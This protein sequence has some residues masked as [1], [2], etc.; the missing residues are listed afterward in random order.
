MK[1]FDSV[2]EKELYFLNQ[3][4]DNTSDKY[5]DILRWAVG[6]VTDG[7]LSLVKIKS[8]LK[9]RIAD[10]DATEGL[11]DIIAQQ[12]QIIIDDKVPELSLNDES[13]G[14]LSFR[15]AIEDRNRA[16]LKS[17]YQF[18]SKVEDE[19]KVKKGVSLEK[20]RRKGVSL[21]KRGRGVLA[22][23]NGVSTLIRDEVNRY[24]RRD[25]M[26]YNTQ[27]RAAREHSYREV[28]N[29]NDQI[30]GWLSIA[31]L[32]NRTSVICVGLANKYYRIEQYKKREDIPN[33][34]PRHPNCRSILLAVEY[35]ERL[36]DYMTQT[37]D[38]F[39]YR[40]P[41]TAIDFLGEE[42]HKLWL[43]SK[44]SINNF[45]DLKKGALFSNEQIRHKFL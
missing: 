3:R 37:A 42:K 27:T 24:N 4:H 1:K 20:K 11:T 14:G 6:A 23:R 30:K 12:R 17:M 35:G 22:Q 2:L 40:N 21:E 41:E 36:K 25:D 10:I 15:E 38:D 31:V 28:D 39:M 13:F 29:N 7:E 19:L 33:Q 8:E 43:E 44:T 34:I 5:K 16:I 26:F 9:K 45:I 32:D 18:V